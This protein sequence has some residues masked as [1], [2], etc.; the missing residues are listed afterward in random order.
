[1]SHIT[2]VHSSDI[3]ELVKEVANLEKKKKELNSELKTVRDRLNVLKKEVMKFLDDNDEE[4]LN[5]KG[6]LFV[7]QEKKKAR[8]EKKEDKNKRIIEVLRNAGIKKPDDILQEIQEASK[9]PKEEVANLA[10]KNL[11]ALDTIEI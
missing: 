8:R 1:M 6:I 9:G 7:K 5:Y 2:G 4:G 3:R 11:V 10:I